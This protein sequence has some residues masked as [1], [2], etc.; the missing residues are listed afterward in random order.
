MARWIAR[1]RDVEED[2]MVDLTCRTLPVSALLLLVDP[3]G[4]RGK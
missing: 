1:R 3:R 4:P 2:L